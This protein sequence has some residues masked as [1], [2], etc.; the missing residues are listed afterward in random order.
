VTE[1]QF[2]E[3]SLSTQE[4]TIMDIQIKEAPRQLFPAR[5]IKTLMVRR[6]WRGDSIVTLHSKADIDGA[7]YDTRENVCVTEFSE[8]VK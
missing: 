4:Q 1:K 8:T 2:G 5:I 3:V 7:N 6:R